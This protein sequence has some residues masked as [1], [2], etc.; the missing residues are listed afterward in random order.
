[1]AEAPAKAPQ[2]LPLALPRLE[3]DT[4][5][6]PEQLAA[7][8]A[9]I[10]AYWQMIGEEAPH[11][12]V[13][14][15]D[16]FR[17][18]AIKRQQAAFYAT[19][20]ADA[21]L[22]GGLM[23]RW[24]VPEGPEATCLEFGCGVGRATVHLA[25]LFGKVI[26]CDVSA[27]HIRLGRRQAKLRGIGT[28]RWHVSTAETLMPATRWDVW[29]SRIVLQHNPPP[30]MAHLLGLAFRRLKPGGLAVFQLP[31][32]LVGY[33]FSVGEYLAEEG[34]PR[35][36]MH[37]LPQAAVFTLAAAA[38]LEV[39]DVRDD[40]VVGDV[41]RWLSTLFVLRRPRRG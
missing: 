5:A 36:E 13:L 32:H 10:S 20:E 23:R 25:P 39:L 19:G 30:V 21:A 6:T 7:M 18:E 2:P 34:P 41:G 17:P 35:M 3:I 28:I 37:V 26:G 9:R 15:Q 31:T 11:W 27:S 33:R 14:T 4:A 38:G 12:S 29:Y 8:L 22:V 1:V 16:R 24:D 40:N